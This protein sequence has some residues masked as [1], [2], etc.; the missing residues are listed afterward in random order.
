MA[1]RQRTEGPKKISANLILY[2]AIVGFII[3]FAIAKK[4][5]FR[6]KNLNTIAQSMASLAVLGI[7]A[8]FILTIGEIDISNGA[9]MSIVPC[10]C[11][12]MLSQGVPFV[13]ALI[14]PVLIVLFLAVLNGVMITRIGLPSFIATFSVQGIAK[15]LTR[16]ITGNTSVKMPSETLIQVFDGETFEIPNSVFWMLAMVLLG[17]FLLKRTDFGRRLHCIGDNK[18]AARLYGIPVQRYKTLAFVVAAGFTIVAG[19]MESLKSSYMQAGTGESQMM[20]SIIVSLIGGTIITGG[21]S[22]PFG[23]LVGA[24]FVTMIKNGLF[25]LSISSYMQ[26]ILVGIIVLVVLSINAITENRNIELNRK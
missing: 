16:I 11:A 15:G 7:G 9:V 10:F 1:S 22:N 17:W 23:T 4:N 25:L 24:F 8:T 19:L 3:F 18:E 14:L 26:D 13:V 6:L 5:Y 2:I 20:Y 21:K 12:V